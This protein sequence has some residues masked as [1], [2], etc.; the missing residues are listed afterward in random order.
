[1]TTLVPLCVAL[2]LLSAAALAAVGH[3]SPPRLDNL[4]A[5]V[6]ALT[7]T[8]FAVLLIFHSAHGTIHYW[9][10]G[11]HPRDGIAIGISFSVEPLGAGIAALIGALMTAALL[12]SFD[13]FHDRVPPHFHVLMLVFL[14]AMVG[15]ALSSDLF[16]MF[17]FFE[18]MSTAAFALTGYRIEQRSVLQGAINFAVVNSIGAFMLLVGIGLVYGRTGAL[19]LAQIG[20]VLS[21][22]GPDGLVV[23]AF[24]L[25]VAGLLTKAGAVPFHFWLSDAYAVAPAPV[26]ILF[27]GVMSDLGLHGVA[28]VYWE[29]FSG[30]LGHGHAD[31]VRG[32]LLGFGLLTALLGAT[33]AFLHSSLKRMLAFVTVSHV[34]IFLAAIALLTARGLAGATVYVVA[35]GLVKGS[36]FC[37][38]GYLALRIGHTDE[39]I[40]RGR[41]RGLLLTGTVIAVGALGLAAVPPLGTFMAYALVDDAAGGI[42][43]RWLPPLLAL[44]TAV[45]GAAVL[46]AAGRIFLGWGSADDELL[47]SA[48]RGEEEDEGERGAARRGVLLWGPSVALLVTGLGVAFAPGIAAH[49][50]DHAERFVDRPAVARETLHDAAS[51]PLPDA[52]VHIAASSYAYGAASALLAVVL[53]WL[54][55]YRGRIP[56]PVREAAGRTLGVGVRR[57]KLLHDGVIGEYVTWLTVGAAALTGLLAVLTR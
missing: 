14:G 12:Q 3:F 24:G 27:A 36:L 2:P 10:G 51:S 13:Y 37:A 20:Q 7:V 53:A 38:V 17:V 19:N 31:A 16:N 22:H 15:F 35:D 30:V 18:L 23:V 34:G 32:V 8:V 11:W 57:L 54:G 1:V 29:G 5:V 50:V 9:F 4:V 25:I 56:L 44:A 52:H 45:T 40:A 33:M 42:G 55:L 46:R 43:Y 39:L 6:V 26:C 21:R 41:G 49:A 48:P 28:R 47:V